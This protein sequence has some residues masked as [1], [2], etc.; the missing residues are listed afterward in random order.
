[1]LSLR[2]VA[3]WWLSRLF[4]KSHGFSC[5]WF[6]HVASCLPKYSFL[7]LVDFSLP[8]GI[9]SIAN[10]HLEIEAIL[11]FD[12][13][14]S[15]CVNKTIFSFDFLCSSSSCFMEN[16]CHVFP[17]RLLLRSLL[18]VV[19]ESFDCPHLSSH[20]QLLVSNW[21]LPSILL[22]T[23]NFCGPWLFFQSISVLLFLCCDG[24][25]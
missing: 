25:R 20:P 16:F 17:P 4:C 11:Q 18:S 5:H 14:S 13:L 21:C 24:G 7:L 19:L 10:F 8:E 3:L 12:F 6:S 1:M 15:A 9:R 2:V 22:T 23:T